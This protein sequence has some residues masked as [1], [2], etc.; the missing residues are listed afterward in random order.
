MTDMIY[1]ITNIQKHPSKN[2][3][4]VALLSII[5]PDLLPII[6]IFYWSINLELMCRRVFSQ[7][8]DEFSQDLSTSCLKK[9]V[10]ELSCSH[11]H[12]WP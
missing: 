1:F 2:T 4:N 12:A 7:S 5:A 11:L 9:C 8:V 10:D 3:V 6:I